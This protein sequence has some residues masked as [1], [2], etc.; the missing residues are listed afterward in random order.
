MNVRAAVGMGIDF[1]FRGNSQI[2]IQMGMKIVPE[3]R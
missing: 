1:Y 3:K 2:G